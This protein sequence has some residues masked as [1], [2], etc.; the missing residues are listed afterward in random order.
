[1]K[2]EGQRR[3]LL[4]HL[5]K[6]WV[7]QRLKH[8]DLSAVPSWLAPCVSTV[9]RYPH[10]IGVGRLSLLISDGTEYDKLLLTASAVLHDAGNGP[11]PHISDQLMEDLLGFRHE[12]A[13]GFVF[14]RS[15]TKDVSI[16]EDYGLDL[17]EVVSVVQ[18]GHKLSPLL[19]S[20]PDLDNADNI[21][22]FMMTI[23]GRPLGEPSYQPKD[24]ATFM[25]SETG[26]KEIPEGVRRRWLRDWEKVYRHVWEDRFNM[27]GWTMLGRALRVLREELTPSFLTMT[28][29]EAFHLIRLKLPKL[30]DGLE[31][32]R[33]RI[34]LD[35]R[36]S[37][38]NGEARKL[39]DPK[40]LRRIEDEL[41]MDTGFED[42]AIGLTVDK[43]LIREKSDHWRVYLVAQNGSEEPKKL[44]EEILSSSTPFTD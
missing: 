40:G 37:L 17:E 32:K 1:M 39:S 38:L 3:R 26:G 8:I 23:P 10:S 18:G 22:R 29:R 34:V 25:S 19:N 28:N 13:L 2:E 14:E 12:G 4:R 27:I 9:S 21:H 5:S 42:W 16:L 44:L 35:K 33:F 20:R 36:Y 24:I 43:P 30:A 31:K 41:C 6:T 7:V 11:F 15:A